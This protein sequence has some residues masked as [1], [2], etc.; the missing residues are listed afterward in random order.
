MPVDVNEKNL[1]ALGALGGRL[2]IPRYERRNLRK[3]IVH[4]GLGHF[5]RAHQ[6]VYV[7]DLLNRGLADTGIFAVNLVPDAYPLCEI[8]AG[9]DYL[10]TLAARGSGGEEDIRVVGSILGCL[11]AAGRSDEALEIMSR[12]ETAAISLTVTEKGYYYDTARGDL[13]WDNADLIGDTRQPERPRTTIGFLAAVLDRRRRAGAGPLTVMSCDNFPSN[14]TILSRCLVSFCRETR[15]ELVPWIEDNVSFPCSMVDRITP[16]AT[17]A[18][19]EDLAGRYGIADRWAVGCE[20]F[21]Q[22]VL[23]ANFQKG[24]PLDRLGEAG[25]LIVKD[26]EPYELM[27]IRL[28]NGSHSALAY[29]AWLLGYGAVTDAAEDPALRRFIRDFYMEEVGATVPPI[30]GIALGDYKDTLIRR[31]SNRHIADT[32]PRLASDG[33]KKIPNAIL[34][35]LAELARGGERPYGAVVLALAFW[36]RFLTGTGEQGE[37]FPLDDPAAAELSAAA[38][39]A[40]EDPAA[41]LRAIRMPELPEPG[42]LARD[43][44]ARLGRIYACGTRR[45]LEEFTGAH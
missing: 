36:A 18:L 17:G 26:V 14:G 41:F 33:S 13:A 22:W 5:H 10:Y 2:G 31:F 24:F 25:A 8:A 35:P 34:G 3:R 21:R 37:R 15:P 30:P 16:A 7:D 29:P 19:A 44:A 42:A 27:K 28:L 45:A 38:R 23:E 6:A 20:D 32:V 39:R 11:N 9:Q 4:L 12:A 40:R 1:G 43:F